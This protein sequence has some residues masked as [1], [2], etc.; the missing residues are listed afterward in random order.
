MDKRRIARMLWTPEALGDVLHLPKG[1]KIIGA[2]MSVDGLYPQFIV[3][4]DEFPEY[5]EGMEVP[6]CSL[7]YTGM[8]FPIKGLEVKLIKDYEE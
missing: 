3:E 7:T 6:R 1:L 2:G 5:V 8:N 4:S